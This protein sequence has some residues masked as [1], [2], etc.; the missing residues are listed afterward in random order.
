MAIYALRTKA[1][2]SARNSKL[3][4]HAALPVDDGNDL[5]CLPR[6]AGYL[7]QM[8]EKTNFY[9]AQVSPDIIRNRKPSPGQPAEFQEVSYSALWFP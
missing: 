4:V 9:I 5:A 1:A 8:L 2:P 3:R 6:T 7:N